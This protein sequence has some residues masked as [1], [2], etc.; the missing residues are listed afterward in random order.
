MLDFPSSPSNAQVYTS[1]NGT[2]WIWDGA[3]WT[4]A[5]YT[6]V[7]TDNHYRN[8]IINGDMSVD[9]RNGGAVVA[10]GG[11]TA[12]SIDRWR[13]ATNISTGAKGTLGQSPSNPVIGFNTALAWTT[14]T[15]YAVTAADYFFINQLVEGYNFNDAQFGTANAQSVVLEFW[16]NSSLTGT[17]GGSLR[18]GA[19]SRSYVF[20]YAIT[21]ANVW[22]KF[23]ITIPGD[24]AG[25]WS[26]AANAAASNLAF[27][28]GMGSTS[29]AAPGSWQAGNFISAPG[30]VSVVGTLNATFNIT[31]VALMVGAAAANAEPEFRKYS[32]NLIDCMRYYQKLGGAIASDILVQGYASTVGGQVAT[33]ISFGSMRGVPIVARVGTWTTTNVT[34]VNL[35]AGT[36]TLG[37]QL[38]STAVGSMLLASTGTGTYLTLDADF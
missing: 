5:A 35:A 20:T 4:S 21:T 22:Q 17:F 2:A 16:A 34:T 11:A 36:N 33:S 8:R 12:Y 7:Y 27:S 3:K 18:N 28:L 9:Q 1:P 37:I 31:G 32:D 25:T 38:Q 13:F 15:A 19:N 26:V 14:T 6:N 10:V 30:A 23:R 29:S 24:T